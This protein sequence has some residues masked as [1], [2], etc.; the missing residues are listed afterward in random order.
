[1]LRSDALPADKEAMTL[2]TSALLP[3]IAAIVL[4]ALGATAGLTY[5]AGSGITTPTTPAATTVTPPTT[6]VVPDVRNQAFVFAKGA[7]EDAGF[8]WKVSGSVR[9]YSSNTVVSQVPAPGTKLIDT[10]A[11]LVTVA[12]KR[13]PHYGEAGD[14]EDVSPYAATADV[15]A[16]LGPAHPALPKLTMP[17]ATVPKAT[18]PKPAATTPPVTT[19]TPAVTTTTP[20]ATTPATTVATTTATTT[21][22]PATTTTAPDVSAT[23]VAKTPVAKTPAVATAAARTPDFVVPGARKEPADEI[24]LSLRAQKLERWVQAHPKPTNS[25]VKHWLYQNEWVV[26]GARLGWWHGADALR[27]LI[28]V[29]QHAQAQWGIG[30]KSEAA[31]RAALG[32]VEAKAR[33]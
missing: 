16:D 25:V 9:G 29:D 26:T 3:R 5:A 27:T 12:L 33:S 22:A 10:G 31:A 18:A 7:L 32:Y 2:R 17:K 4:V 8:A 1:M 30:A 11:P 21:T 23:P 19:T 24:P 14:P 20:A 15:N 13:N 28:A 6:I